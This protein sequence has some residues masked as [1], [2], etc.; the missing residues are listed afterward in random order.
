MARGKSVKLLS[1]LPTNY[2]PDWLER[3]DKRTKIWRAVMPRI[4]A[5]ESDAGGHDNITHAKRSLI[6]RAA[7][8]ELLAET[9][10]YKFTS[11]QPID[12]GAY[13]Q[14]LNSMLGIYRVLGVERKMKRAPSLR[15]YAATID[16]QKGVK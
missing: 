6:R 14:A 10:E 9:E 12:V 11:G 2:S 3:F 1:Q 7:F 4:H 13:T 16:Q 8:M 15:E 5:L